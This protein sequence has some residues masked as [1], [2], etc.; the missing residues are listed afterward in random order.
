MGGGGVG[1]G[2]V[3]GGGG[4]GTYPGG[5]GGTIEGGPSGIQSRSIPSGCAP[6]RAGAVMI[7]ISTSFFMVP[8]V[9]AIRG[10]HLKG[11][12]E[13]KSV[14]PGFRHLMQIHPANDRFRKTHS[15]SLKAC[16]RRPS[17]S[18]VFCGNIAP[19]RAFALFN[20]SSGDKPFS[21]LKSQ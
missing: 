21:R 10:S 19:R 9:Y 15:T 7:A 17:F 13:K 3:P 20:T 2:N 4:G 6:I 18:D 5:G 12:A 1:S 11:K 14:H 16:R 8:Y